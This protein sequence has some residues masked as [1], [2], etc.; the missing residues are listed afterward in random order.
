MAAGPGEAVAGQEE[1]AEVA[2]GGAG[3]GGDVEAVATGEA[4]GRG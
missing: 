3:A 1:G 4:P 2:E